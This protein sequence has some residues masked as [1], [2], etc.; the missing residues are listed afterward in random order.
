MQELYSIMRDL[1][2]IEYNQESLLHILTILDKAYNETESKEAALVANAVKYYLK[3]LQS[4]LRASI[5]RIDNYLAKN[6][7]GR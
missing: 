2:D 7:K 3:G 1:L 4:E 5:S 6:T